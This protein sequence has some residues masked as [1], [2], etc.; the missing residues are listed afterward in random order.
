[1]TGSLSPRAAYLLTKIVVF[2]VA[3]VLTW[4]LSRMIGP[5]A[6]WGLG[7]FGLVLVALTAVVFLAFG[8]R[9]SKAGDEVRDDEPVEE[10]DP[11]IPVELGIEDWIDLHSFPPRDIPDVV[12][13][14][15]DAAHARGFR[16]VRLIHGRGIGVQRERT[17]SV[18]AKHPLVES[19]SDATPD[20]GGWGATVARLRDEPATEA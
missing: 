16:E 11:E 17:R 2:A 12:T 6:W 10:L 14:Y 4:P 18:L 8:R 3:A 9:S 1:V 5:K 13:D 7:V 15:L 20:G 19:F